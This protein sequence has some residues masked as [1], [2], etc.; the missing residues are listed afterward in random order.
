V[1]HA[2]ESTKKKDSAEMKIKIFDN[3][4]HVRLPSHYQELIYLTKKG[5]TR[6]IPKTLI[7]SAKS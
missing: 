7:E 4:A 2:L 5:T 3:E 6:R 1:E